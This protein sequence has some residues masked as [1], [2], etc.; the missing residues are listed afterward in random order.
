MN[1][2]RRGFA[3]VTAILAIMILMALG[4]LVISV[5]TGDLKISSRVVGEKKALAAAETGIHR[6]M[7]DFN[8][9]TM[10]TDSVN[11]RVGVTYQV[12][13]ATDPASRYTISQRGPS[14]RGTGDAPTA[15]VFDQRRPAVGTTVLCRPSNG[16]EYQ[17]RQFR[18]DQ[19][20]N[21]LRPHQH[22]HRVAVGAKWIQGD[23][24]V[25]MNFIHARIIGFSA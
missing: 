16:Q 23:G 1:G 15:R 3:L 8:P 18:S 22:Y 10:L 9:A 4:Y 5:S 19:R 2:S 24:Q 14:H 21:G 13:S 7:Q 6:M 11:A 20:G 12:D 25:L 17:L